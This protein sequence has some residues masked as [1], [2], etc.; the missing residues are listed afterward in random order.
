MAGRWQAEVSKLNP[1]EWMRKTT[2]DQ[3]ARLREMLR[4]DLAVN[5]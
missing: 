1:P 4:P 5:S 2:E 3:V